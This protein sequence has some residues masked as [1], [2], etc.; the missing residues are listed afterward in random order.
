MI[1]TRAFRAAKTWLRTRRERDLPTEEA[2]LER[3]AEH[4]DYIRGN[5][6]AAAGP[7]LST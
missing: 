4:D 5:A 7:T 1:V 2:L 3:D 6:A